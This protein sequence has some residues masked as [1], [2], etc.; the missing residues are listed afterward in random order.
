MT[1]TPIKVPTEADGEAAAA[2]IVIVRPEAPM[3]FVRRP[4][5]VTNAIALGQQLADALL[6]ARALIHRTPTD[7]TIMVDGLRR[8]Y[9]SHDPAE[10]D[11]LLWRRFEEAR[12]THTRLEQA[13]QAAREALDVERPAL[14]QAQA[15][16]EALAARR[17][18]ATVQEEASNAR[19]EAV[20]R[21][22]SVGIECQQRAAALA[23]LER[24]LPA[25][26]QALGPLTEAV[27]RVLEAVGTVDREALV[28][29]LRE[30]GEL[31]HLRSRVERLRTMANTHAAEIDEWRQRLNRP[32]R[33]PRVMFPWPPAPVWEALLAEAVEAPELIWDDDPK[34]PG[35]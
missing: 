28:R 19:P 18:P 3:P 9:Y 34:R 14:E 26:E 27:T 32:V 15:E 8:W 5:P 33:V 24:L 6:A 4:G 22:L 12:Q 7:L 20:R 30:S 11:R 1:R 25:P 10:R 2:P 17:L 31:E 23:E 35:I 13:I 21:Y 29:R 16:H